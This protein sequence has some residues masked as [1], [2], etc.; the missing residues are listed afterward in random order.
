MTSHPV[1]RAIIIEVCTRHGVHEHDLCSPWR[2]CSPCRRRVLGEA[3]AEAS[4]QLRREGR[5]STT[6][7]ARAMGYTSHSSVI[8]ASRRHARRQEAAA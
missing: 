3:R 5:W 8:D 7:I 4:F 1:M 2:A 6:E